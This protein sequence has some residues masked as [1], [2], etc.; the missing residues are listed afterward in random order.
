MMRLR[1]ATSETFFAVSF[2]RGVLRRDRSAASETPSDPSI[3][4][5][6]NLVSSSLQSII[7]AIAGLLLCTKHGMNLEEAD[8]NRG[9]FQTDTRPPLP[10]SQGLARDVFSWAELLSGGSSRLGEAHRAG[11]IRWSKPVLI[12]R[13]AVMRQ[14]IERPNGTEQSRARGVGL[15]I[16]DRIGSRGKTAMDEWIGEFEKRAGPRLRRFELPRN[17]AQCA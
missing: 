9:K 14:N 6:L 12:G 17:E 13:V 5:L 10:N 4:L 7:R 8:V 2:R 1:S 3:Q 11:Q 15:W 16:M